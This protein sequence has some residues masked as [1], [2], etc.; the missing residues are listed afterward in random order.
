MDTSQI[1]LTP[2]PVQSMIDQIIAAIN[3]AFETKQRLEFEEKLLTATETCKI[4]IP[5]IAKS[6]LSQWT[7][8]GLIPVHRIGGRIFYK[9]SEVIDAAK[10]VRKY[11]RSKQVV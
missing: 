6:T 11:D 7:T 3:N 1:L 8:Q 10:R 5:Q 2:V 9:Y 4:F